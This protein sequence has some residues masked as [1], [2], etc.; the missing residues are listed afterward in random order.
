MSVPPQPVL[1]KHGTA[2][3]CPWWLNGLEHSTCWE[4]ESPSGRDIFC[5]RGFGTF[6]RAPDRVPKMNLVARAQL[7]YQLLT[8]LQKS[9]YRESQCSKTWG[10]GCLVV[11]VPLG[12]RHFLSQR[13]WHFHKNTR[14]CVKNECCCPCTVSTSNYNLSSKMFVPP[15]SVFKNMGQWMAVPDGSMG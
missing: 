8:V 9:L 6:T 12:L 4:F 7:T 2:D 15:E 3:V 11:R 14:S 13:R 5:L 1:K 10:S